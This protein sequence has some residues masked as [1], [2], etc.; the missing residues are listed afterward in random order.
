MEEYPWFKSYPK[1]VPHTVDIT[2]YSS[3]M[4]IVDEALSQFSDKPA[5]SCM[6]KTIT[7]REVDKISRDFA[8]YLQSIGLKKGDRIALQMPNVLQYPAINQDAKLL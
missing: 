5:F 4:E 8:A 7:Y 6:D 3:V 2:T 1:S